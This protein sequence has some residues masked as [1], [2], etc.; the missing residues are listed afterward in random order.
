MNAQVVFIYLQAP[1]L[2]LN[3]LKLQ[4]NKQIAINMSFKLLNLFYILL[5]IYSNT[6]TH[7][8]PYA[9]SV[10]FRLVH[11]LTLMTET[12]RNILSLKSFS[13]FYLNVCFGSAWWMI[14]LTNQFYLDKLP[15][16]ED[17]KGKKDGFV[18][19]FNTEAQGYCYCG[20]SPTWCSGRTDW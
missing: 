17:R 8:H 10:L 2:H 7:T 20:C 6:H 4:I 11:W 14:A 13:P 19:V 18:E 16:R 15:S 12:T 3:T 5:Y 1:V 9:P